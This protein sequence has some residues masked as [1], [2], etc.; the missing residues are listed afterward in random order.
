MDKNSHSM[1]TEYIAPII[2]Y[3]YDPERNLHVLILVWC[4]PPPPVWSSQSARTKTSMHA[5]SQARAHSFCLLRLSHDGRK[6]GG[7]SPQWAASR[8]GQRT[9]QCFLPRPPS[10]NRAALTDGPPP[11]S[12]CRRVEQAWGNRPKK[13][14]TKKLMWL[15][16]RR[17]RSN[18]SCWTQSIDIFFSPYFSQHFGIIGRWCTFICS[19]VKRLPSSK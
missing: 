10:T 11:T 13:T 14:T 3:C 7:N 16:R 18:D 4:L 17:R 6:E 12:S 8:T 19:R 5:S 15:E 2:S 1:N 9:S